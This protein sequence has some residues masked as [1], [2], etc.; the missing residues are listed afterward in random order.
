MTANPI[1]IDDPQVR[2]S[3]LWAI[4]LYAAGGIQLLE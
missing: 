2:L 3:C 4:L 1:H